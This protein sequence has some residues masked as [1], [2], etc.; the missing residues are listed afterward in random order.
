MPKDDKPKSIGVMIDEYLNELFEATPYF[1]LQETLA[2]ILYRSW[3]FQGHDL[4]KKTLDE[5]TFEEIDEIRE[6]LNLV[7]ADIMKTIQPF[8]G[9]NAYAINKDANFCEKFN[10][11]GGILY[12]LTQ[13]QMEL[14]PP[15]PNMSAYA[16]HAPDPSAPPMDDDGAGMSAKLLKHDYSAYPAAGPASQPQRQQRT[17]YYSSNNSYFVTDLC[18]GYRHHHHGIFGSYLHHEGFS[19]GFSKQK[20]DRIL[21]W[22]SCYSDGWVEGR[23]MRLTFDVTKSGVQLTA[24]VVETSVN[25]T[26][27]AGKFV[28]NTAADAAPVVFKGIGQAGSKLADVGG[29]AA[30]GLGQAFQGLGRQAV[31]PLQQLGRG[32]VDVGGNVVKGVSNGVESV[33]DCCK[34][35]ACGCKDVTGDATKAVFKPVVH[36]LMS[37]GHGMGKGAMKGARFM[38][39]AGGDIVKG[40]GH[41][42]GKAV[43]VVGSAGSGICD[44]CGGMGKCVSGCGSDVG[45]FVCEVIGGIG[46][47]CSNCG[48]M[49]CCDEGCAKICGGIA[50]GCATVGSWIGSL[51]APEKKKKSDEDEELV[52]AAAEEVAADSAAANSTYATGMLAAKAVWAATMGVSA[53]IKTLQLIYNMM[54]PDEMDPTQREEA[55]YALTAGFVAGGAMLVTG[56]WIMPAA[57][58]V[59]GINTGIA[60]GVTGVRLAPEFSEMHYRRRIKAAFN[61]EY[62]TQVCVENPLANVLTRAELNALAKPFAANNS[63]SEAYARKLFAEANHALLETE[64]Q[65]KKDSLNSSW[66]VVRK[67]R[68]FSQFTWFCD[69]CN[70]AN[71]LEMGT[72]ET[73]EHQR[74]AIAAREGIRCLKRGEQL[75]QDPV[76]EPLKH[77]RKGN[78][79]RR[80]AVNQ[81]ERNSVPTSFVGEFVPPVQPSAPPAYNGRLG[82]I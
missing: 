45:K 43:D 15:A 35:A 47:C 19:A 75:P 60:M 57:C 17:R 53:A 18:F 26:I 25:H 12:E 72:D 77:V 29:D 61:D 38:G 73:R 80:V 71:K 23:L 66:W 52:R 74:R 40:I 68:Q 32:M 67:F 69:P 14:V 13:A 42:G 79:I 55:K 82:M 7:V 54:K 1:D 8:I 62:D 58:G 46:H 6:D 11:Y 36:G 78:A 41:V 37:A 27:T 48:K 4:Y 34:N 59:G 49:N 21:M 2:Q 9:D 5:L 65:A 3:I 30:K 39:D 50:T 31:P 56:T 64:R 44:C 20:G 22:N 63:V 33:G 70:V 24:K 76:I 81:F 51:F 10:N 28:A 16:V